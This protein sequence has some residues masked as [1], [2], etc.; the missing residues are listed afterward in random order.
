MSNCPNVPEPSISTSFVTHKELTAHHESCTVHSM[1]PIWVLLAIMGM[2]TGAV[3]ALW[4]MEGKGR[5]RDD[6]FTTKLGALRNEFTS[7]IAVANTVQNSAEID[8][9]RL[10]TELETWRIRVDK[11]HDDILLEQKITASALA[12]LQSKQASGIPA[13]D[14]SATLA[15][16]ERRTP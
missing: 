4:L 16:L 14:G 3:S 15:A 10:A 9:K 5:D 11:W 7:A 13:L 6:E 2:V 8:K 12:V 1:V